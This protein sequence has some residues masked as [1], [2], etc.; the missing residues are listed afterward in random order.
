MPQ[1]L[2]IAEYAMGSCA[3]NISWTAPDNIALSDITNFTIYVD[4]K[5]IR[6]STSLSV[7]HS[8]SSCGS[9]NVSVSAVDRCNRQGRPSA[10]NE[11]ICKC[12]GDGNDNSAAGNRKYSNN[13]K[14]VKSHKFLFKFT[15]STVVPIVV[16]VVAVVTVVLV[17]VSI[18]IIVMLIIVKR[19]GRTKKITPSSSGVNEKVCSG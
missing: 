3:L 12:M 17:I 6:N 15:A 19:Q 4:G 8:V 18:A 16:G 9:H 14:A 11:T 5:N 13:F 10:N 7:L 2:V 1:V